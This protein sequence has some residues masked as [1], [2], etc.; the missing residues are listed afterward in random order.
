MQNHVK[1]FCMKPHTTQKS[2]SPKILKICFG[3]GWWKIYFDVSCT[4]VHS[5]CKVCHLT[6]YT[7]PK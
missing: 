3:G 1:Q 2:T 5:P 7:K 4:L 6:S